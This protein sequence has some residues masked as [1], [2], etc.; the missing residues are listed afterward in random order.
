M[1]LKLHV[2]SPVVL[3]HHLQGLWFRR[4]RPKIQGHKDLSECEICGDLKGKGEWWQK[5]TCKLECW[6]LVRDFLQDVLH[7]HYQFTCFLCDLIKKAL[8]ESGTVL[9]RDGNTKLINTLLTSPLIFGG[10]SHSSPITVQEY[11]CSTLNKN[12]QES[13]EL[14]KKPHTFTFIWRLIWSACAKGKC[15]FAKDRESKRAPRKS[16]KMI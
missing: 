2:V 15:W 5:K 6:L 12:R 14:R 11:H 4:P 7:I 3:S 9:T 1:L 8:W 13:I 10:G 16:R